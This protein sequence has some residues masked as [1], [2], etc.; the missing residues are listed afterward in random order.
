[1]TV[2]DIRFGVLTGDRSAS[3]A[4]AE[5]DAVARATPPHLPPTP[6]EVGRRRRC[7]T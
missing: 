4:G 2:G 3:D 7:A 1:M 6:E 5:N